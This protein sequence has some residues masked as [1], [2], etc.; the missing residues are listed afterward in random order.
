MVSVISALDQSR[1][2]AGEGWNGHPEHEWETDTNMIALR[3]RLVQ[4]F[5]QMVRTDSKEKILSLAKAHR[6]LIDDLV[7]KDPEDHSRVMD[8]LKLLPLQTRDIR[9]G[10]G[11]RTLAYSQLL[12]WY[13]VGYT[14]YAEAVFRRWLGVDGGF[15][16]G[17]WKDVKLFSEFVKW[18]APESARTKHPLVLYGIRLLADQLRKDQHSVNPS[19]A[20][21]WTPGEKCKRFAWIFRAVADQIFPPSVSNASSG[22]EPKEARASRHRR[23]RKMLSGLNQKIRTT[24]VMM[25]GGR[26]SDIDFTRVSSVTIQK[27]KRAFFNLPKSKLIISKGKFVSSKFDDKTPTDDGTTPERSKTEDRRMCATNLRTHVDRSAKGEVEVKAKNTSLFDLIR[28][29]IKCATLSA[30][31]DERKIL[32]EQWKSNRSVN[33][34]GLPPMIPMVDVSGSM[35]TPNFIPLYNA[36]GLGLRAS[37]M[38]HPAFRNRIMTFS[39][40]PSWVALP[41][42]AGFVERIRILQ[43]APWGMNTNFYKALDLILDTMVSNSIPPEEAK[44]MVLAVFSDMQID[45]ASKQTTSARLSMHAEIKRRYNA[46]GYE[47]PHILYWNL[48]G[49]SGFPNVGTEMN[50]TMVSGFNPALLNAFESKGIE[51]LST[52]TPFAFVEEILRKYHLEVDAL[53]RAEAKLSALLDEIEEVIPN[54]LEDRMRE[55]DAKE[56]TLEVS[57]DKEKEVV[58]EFLHCHSPS[59]DDRTSA[60][61]CCADFC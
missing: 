28:D 20:A 1:M 23:L 54:G 57:L 48:N 14:E 12:L 34:P 5:F 33:R 51:E 55:A 30:D 17:S 26:W 18:I 4:L 37:E 2:P 38:T 6:S 41:E 15:P 8:L 3:E 35:T 60:R 44:G 9:S 45:T 21:K 43:R 61:S 10:K 39:E 56:E 13:D 32:E 22:G 25:C 46:V 27:H 52:M 16:L 19:L 53:E 42:K 49:T 40:S 47:P 7:E 31:A 50:T 11:E 58:A 59:S 36:M 29:A 24:E